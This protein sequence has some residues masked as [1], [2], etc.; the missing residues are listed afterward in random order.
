MPDQRN[1][2]QLTRRGLLIGA[3]GVIVLGAAAV[4]GVE[5]NILPGRSTLY[6]A[7]GWDGPQ[8]VIPKTKPGPIV[9]GS[10]TSAARL[11][12]TSRWELAYPPGSE[13]GDKLPVLVGLH[14][15][16]GSHRSMFGDHLGLEYFL[17]QAVADG[18]APFAI[19]SVDG[20]SS[21]WHKRLTGENSAAMVT[22]EFLPLLAEHGIDTSLLGLLGFSMG[23]FGA[24]YIAGLLGAAKCRVVV[25]E[26]PALWTSY[27]RSAHGAFD[28]AADFAACTPF[29]KQAELDGMGVMVDCGTG[30]GFYP[31]AEKYVAGFTTKPRSDFPAGG[32]NDSFWRRLAPMQLRFVGEKLAS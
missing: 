17:A 30:D 5:S 9:M 11:G 32:H 14:G 23:G 19:A 2:A 6:R 26:S 8:G 12:K 29:G 25:A 1:R 31:T 24:L 3:G 10:F 22:D 15:F 16:G 13:A 4:A 28:S 7:M 20:G 27:A 21:Y 18:V